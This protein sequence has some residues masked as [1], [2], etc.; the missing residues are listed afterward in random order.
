[1]MMFIF[2]EVYQQIHDNGAYF[3]QTFKHH[4]HDDDGHFQVIYHHINA[5]DGH[6]SRSIPSHS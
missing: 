6:F 5:D 1:M 4:I 2:Q 3:F